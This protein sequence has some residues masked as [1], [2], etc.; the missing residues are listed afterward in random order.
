MR[1]GY[2]RKVTPDFE[3]RCPRFRGTGVRMACY[4]PNRSQ[5]HSESRFK[6]IRIPMKNLKSEKRC[7]LSPSRKVC[8]AQ[9]AFLVALALQVLG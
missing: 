7:G 2:G 5:I 4:C 9:R 1:E 6:R 8:Y 3:L